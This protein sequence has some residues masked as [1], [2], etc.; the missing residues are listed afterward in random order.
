MQNLCSKPSVLAVTDSI[1]R[2]IMSIKI[3]D[4]NSCKFWNLN[5]RIAKVNIG[6]Y[7]LVTMRSIFKRSRTCDNFFRSSTKGKLKWFC[8]LSS[9]SFFFFW[10][11]W[12]RHFV[13]RVL[14]CLKVQSKNTFFRNYSSNKIVTKTKWNWNHGKIRSWLEIRHKKNSK[15][16]PNYPEK[17]K[18]PHTLIKPSCLTTSVPHLTP[19]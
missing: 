15:L 3:L 12:I 17:K 2:K 19:F 14:L 7:A 18:W 1:N 16:P 5:G 13:V 9:F 10:K 6:W 4:Q 11:P 8:L